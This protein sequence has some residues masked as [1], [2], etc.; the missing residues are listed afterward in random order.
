M[1]LGRS[2]EALPMIVQSMPA[3]RRI[4][5][6]SADLSEPLYFLAEANDETGHFEDA[7]AAVKEAIAVQTGKIAPT[8]R[9]F[10]A[11][12]WLWARALVGEHRYRDALPHAENADRLLVSSAV[13]PGA[14]KTAAEA[15]QLLLDIQSHLASSGT[16]KNNQKD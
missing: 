3:W 8:D 9:R 10:G 16:Q 6:D 13:S 11:L 2:Q 14:K 15:H 12:D 5:G 4:L 7:E 1:K